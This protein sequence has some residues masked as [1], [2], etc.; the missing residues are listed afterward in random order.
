MVS[1]VTFLSPIKFELVFVY[2][3]VRVK[4]IYSFIFTWGHP[5]VPAT[6]IEK[7]VLFP[8]NFL[9][10]CCKPIDYICVS[11]FLDCL[12]CCI[13]PHICLMPIRHSV[14]YFSFIKSCAIR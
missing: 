5:I 4:I 3:E 2:G 9:V 8:L 11:L 13:D 7:I 1:A 14:D 6:F 10:L 12:F